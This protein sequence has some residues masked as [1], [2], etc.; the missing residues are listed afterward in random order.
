MMLEYELVLSAYLLS[1][2]IYGLI[3]SRNM[4]RAVMCLEHILNA[5]NINFVTFSDLFDSRQL[6]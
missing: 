6:K 4:V 2:G 5:V 1:I 3:T